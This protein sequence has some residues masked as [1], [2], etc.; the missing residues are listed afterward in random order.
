MVAYGIVGCRAFRSGSD[1]Q[2]V[3]DVYKRQVLYLI[4]CS[5][6]RGVSTGH[7]PLSNGFETMQFLALTILLIAFF[8]SLHSD[9]FLSFGM[10]SSGLALI[11]VYKRQGLKKSYQLGIDNGSP[12]P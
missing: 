12:S 2:K 8:L 10:L 11:D 9:L 5:I 7:I 1:S 4:G 3:I 6:L